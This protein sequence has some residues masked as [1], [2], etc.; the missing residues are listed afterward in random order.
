MC[1]ERY[2]DCQ[3]E[4]QYREEPVY[5]DKCSYTR[6]RWVEAAREE[7]SGRDDLPRWPL[8]VSSE[9]ERAERTEHYSVTFSFTQHDEPDQHTLEEDSLT[10]YEA[11]TPGEP[12]LLTVTNA[13]RVK[14][15]QRPGPL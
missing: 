11:W 1:D 14:D 3:M 5:D 7:A 9:L 4:T 8:E 13:G 12:V 2:E 15:I 6:W 10:L